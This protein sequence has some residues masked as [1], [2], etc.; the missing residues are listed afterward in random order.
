MASSLGSAFGVAISSTVYSTF[1]GTTS[2]ETAATF[3]IITNVI[4]GDSL[5]HFH[6]MDGAPG[7]RKSDKGSFNTWLT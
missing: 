3:G 2:L 5:H 1:T 4:F 7:Y 6:P